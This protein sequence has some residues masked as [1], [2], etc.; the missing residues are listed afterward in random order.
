MTIAARAV[1]SPI[2]SAI[3]HP[4]LGEWSTLVDEARAL[5][6]VIWLDP[7]E[8]ASL[9]QDSAATTAVTAA[10]DP[11]GYIRDRS[12]NGR[13]ATQGTDAAR[14]TYQV[15]SAGRAYLSFDGSGD[16]LVTAA[17]DLSAGDAITV[18]AAVRKLSDAAQGIVIESSA[19]IVSNTG[20]FSMG[21]PAAAGALYGFRSKGSTLVSIQAG[22]YTAPITNVVTGIADIS[23]DSV[24]LR[25]DGTQVQS[26]ANDQGTGNYGNHA[27]YIGSRGGSGTYFSGRIYQLLVKAGVASAD[28]L[29]IMERLAALRCGVAL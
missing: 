27:F 28:E 1:R 2:R 18:V 21:A 9:Y 17:I 7:Q 14:P 3:Y 10:G 11:V 5:D 16:G 19:T 26:S 8:F 15:D 6:L 24:L 22:T 25:V 13:H 29:R 12:G 20:T 4:Q 23:A